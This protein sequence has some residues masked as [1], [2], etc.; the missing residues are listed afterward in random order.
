M[1]SLLIMVE[2]EDIPRDNTRTITHILGPD[3][4]VSIHIIQLCEDFST[5]NR[6]SF[7]PVVLSDNY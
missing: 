5:M 6:N 1:V 3:R 2:W 4:Q 7:I